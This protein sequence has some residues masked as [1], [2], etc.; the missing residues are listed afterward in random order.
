MRKREAGGHVRPREARE[1]LQRHRAHA[2]AP[3]HVLATEPA[4]AAAVGHSTW[5]EFLGCLPENDGPNIRGQ[6]IAYYEFVQKM[7]TD[8]A[9]KPEELR[10]CPRINTVK[11]WEE[12]MKSW[13]ALANLAFW[14]LNFPTS[15]IA[16]ERVGA[17][18]RGIEA[19][20]TRSGQNHE[21][22]ERELK[23][24]CNLAFVESMLREKIALYGTF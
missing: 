1:A 23:V 20:W 5:K 4:A 9:G 14:H 13:P 3:L 10:L 2:Q 17:I 11:F 7:H 24:K 18:M 19:V 8:D 12:K 6:Y 22:T 21:T 16:C 15:N